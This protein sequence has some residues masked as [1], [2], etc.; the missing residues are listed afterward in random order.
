MNPSEPLDAVITGYAYEN[1]TFALGVLE[2]GPQAKGWVSTEMLCTLDNFIKTV[3]FSDRIFI[4]PLHVELSEVPDNDGSSHLDAKF[5]MN[6]AFG[7]SAQTKSL[8]DKEGIFHLLPKFGPDD[9]TVKSVQRTETLL[10]NVKVMEHPFCCLKC[11]WPGESLVFFQE[12]L[13]YDIV[14]LEALIHQCGL[15]HFKP[16]FPGEHLYLGL[17]AD[18][19]QSQTIADLA[20]RRL[21]TLVRKKLSELNEQQVPLGAMPLPVLPPLFV[22][23]LLSE[24]S[25][26]T[27]LT[28]TMFQMRKSTAFTRFRECITK[29]HKMLESDDAADRIKASEVIKMFDEFDFQAK[30][31]PEQWFKNGFKAIKA[32]LSASHG[33]VTEP[34]EEIFELSTI[35]FRSL[36]KHP[37]LAL[38]EF[39]TTKASQKKLNAYLQTNFG[40]QFNLMDLNSVATM[41]WLPETAKQWSE[42]KVSFEALPERCDSSAPINGRPCLFQT[43]TAGS[44]PSFDKI[45]QELLK[46]TVKIDPGVG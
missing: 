39:G 24:C 10:K 28:A 5:E 20:V 43:K 35:L 22:S 44:G 21:R 40:D 33:N 1:V 12:M 17:R 37:L 15:D 3:L 8:F 30:T 31:G 38:E 6:P 14:F 2:A 26:R 23:R 27:Q 36:S 34:V 4:Y 32:I 11:S 42:E 13:V 16:V 41:L 18:T 19:N 9:T 45:L 46:N 29:C 7:A 25:D